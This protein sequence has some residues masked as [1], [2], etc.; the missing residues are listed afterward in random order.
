MYSPKTATSSFAQ[1]AASVLET[2]KRLAAQAP[3]T[4]TSADD[5]Q[6]VVAFKQ[7]KTALSWGTEYEVRVSGG[8]SGSEVAVTAGGVDG[9]PRAM[10]D[11]MK[12]NKAAKK[13]LGDLAQALGA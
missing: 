6:G 13:F 5:A 8:S 3:Y 12:H 11:G 9:A 4:T 7:G 2:V 10:L 1:P